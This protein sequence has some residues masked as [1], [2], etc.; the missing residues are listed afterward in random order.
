MHYTDVKARS[1]ARIAWLKRRLC[2]VRRIYAWEPR[3]A[4]SNVSIDMTLWGRDQNPLQRNE[5]VESDAPD[6]WPS[7]VHRTFA[8]QDR[9]YGKV[10]FR[11]PRRIPCGRIKVSKVMH[12]SAA[13]RRRKLTVHHLFCVNFSGL[14]NL[15]ASTGKTLRLSWKH[16]GAKR[17]TR[18]QT[19]PC[20]QG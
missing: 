18:P 8:L 1:E 14:A 3:W 13:R 2:N 17:Q 11:T 10:L 5:S 7:T 20:Y 19:F 15:S 9:L 6:S 12:Q 4:A 16:Y